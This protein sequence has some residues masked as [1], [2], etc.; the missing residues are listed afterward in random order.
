[1]RSCSFDHGLD[2]EVFHKVFPC[3]LLRTFSQVIAE[4]LKSLSP[5]FKFAE[6][7][8]YHFT[9]SRVSAAPDLLPDKVFPVS[10]E[11]Q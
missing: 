7:S 8:S 4:S 1:M 2:I 11:A 3:G 5:V 6:R 9:G 10:T